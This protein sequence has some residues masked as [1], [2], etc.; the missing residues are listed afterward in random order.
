VA[1]C[2]GC[3]RSATWDLELTNCAFSRTRIQTAQTSKR[4]SRLLFTECSSSL[5]PGRD[6]E[7]L[8]PSIWEYVH[9]HGRTYH[10]YMAGGRHRLRH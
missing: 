5:T 4:A 9:Q 10:R 8:T 7:S 3:P 2:Q 6:T 1:T